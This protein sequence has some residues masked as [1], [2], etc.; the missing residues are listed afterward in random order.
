LGIEIARW[1]AGVK[2]VNQTYIETA[3][4][5]VQV[6]PLVF[7]DE[8]LAL[9]GGTAIN[10]FLR[11]MP[12]LSVDLDLTFT[13]HRVKRSDAL[14]AINN[15][16]REAEGRL[17]RRGFQ[18]QI[19]STRDGIEAK[20]LIRRGKIEV[21]IETNYVIRG[22]TNP[23][24][25]ASLTPMAKEVLLA[26]LE[27]PILSAEDIY[28]GKLVA[29]LDRQH[30][31]DLFDVLQLFANEGITPGIRRS[32]VVYLASHNRPIHE[33][34]FPTEIDISREYEST[35]RGMTTEP[36]ELSEL[37]SVRSRLLHELPR[38][39]P[40]AERQFL[41]SLADAEPQWQL[42][43]VEHAQELPAIKWKVQNLQKLAIENKAKLRAQADELA[44]RFESL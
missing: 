8:R 29:A 13:D 22:T 39:L 18:T 26:D 17:Q 21:K 6:A 15:A 3:R 33:V 43:D 42:L 20:L 41:M 34:L 4:M 35:F 44:H 36:I 38:S 19:A 7:T 40:T 11:N 12:R 25:R 24:R 10:L 14:A 1:P 28:G 27:V 16:I 30:P 31:R 23:P 37:L 32:F 5:M 9:K 2:T